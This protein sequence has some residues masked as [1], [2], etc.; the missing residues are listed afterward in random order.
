MRKLIIV[1][2][3]VLLC[4]SRAALAWNQTGHMTVALIAWRELSDSQKQQASELLKAH[5]HYTKLLLEHKPDNVNE[6]EWAFI[7]AAVWPDMVRPA[8]PG[9]DWA[10]PNGWSARSNR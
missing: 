2:G 8:R 6:S 1:V 7:R 9:I 3:L 10:W 4:G 5:P